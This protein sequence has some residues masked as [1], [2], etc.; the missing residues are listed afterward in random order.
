ML[1]A[2]LLHTRAGRKTVEMSTNCANTSPK[3]NSTSKKRILRYV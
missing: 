3:T 2:L 1:I